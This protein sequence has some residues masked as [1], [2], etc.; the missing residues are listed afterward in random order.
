[1]L[2]ELMLFC[3]M[4]KLFD[5]MMMGFKYQLVCATRLEQMVEVRQSPFSWSA[6]L[7]GL[8]RGLSVS[9][10]CQVTILHL[11]TVRSMVAGFTDQATLDLLD[12]VQSCVTRTYS[13]LNMGQQ[14][15]LRQTL[16]RFFQ[17]KRVKVSLFLQEGIQ[18]SA[19]RL[20]HPSPNNSYVGS[21]TYYDLGGGVEQQEKLKLQALQVCGDTGQL[22]C[23][24][25]YECMFLQPLSNP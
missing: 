18:S 13:H 21:V 6:W 11:A 24:Y 17:D 7:G 2:L 19:G 3:S 8:L 5:L 20:I 16:L 23:K 12:N 9:A 14:H 15:L 10:S 22:G 4:D 25:M 1:M